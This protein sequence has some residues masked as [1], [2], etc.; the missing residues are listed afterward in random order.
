MSQLENMPLI[1]HRGVALGGF[2][3][4]CEWPRQARSQHGTI[5]V[6][7]A[8]LLIVIL[9]FCRL[10]LDLSRLYNR[11]VEMQN[12]TDAVALAAARKLDGTPAG[13]AA[14]VTAAQQMAATFRYQYNQLPV[15]WSDAA[16]T[17]GTS[18][19]RA[20]SWVDS[21]TAAGQ[22]AKIFT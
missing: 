9:G 6:M 8:V 11:K 21:G 2:G 20:G 5:A 1:C 4:P 12:M 7:F 10:A 3:C 15:N 22:A 19:S 16:L 17:F 13:I 14:A 18:S